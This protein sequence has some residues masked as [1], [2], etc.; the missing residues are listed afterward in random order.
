MNKVSVSGLILCLT[1]LSPSVKAMEQK[2]DTPTAPAAVQAEAAQPV[3]V[4]NKICPV[5]GEKIEKTAMGDPV[6][7]EYK[8]KIYNLCCPMCPKDFNKDPKKYSA[9]ADKEVSEQV[10]VQK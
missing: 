5:S 3:E 7:I 10:S 2:K 4:G 8:G 1:V 6:K 9:I